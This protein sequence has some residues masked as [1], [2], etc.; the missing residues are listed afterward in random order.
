MNENLLNNEFSQKLM[1]KIYEFAT[2]RTFEEG[3]VIVQDNSYSR[4]I[5]FIT[6]GS[7]KVMRTDD[8][9]NEILLYYISGGD[10]C[11]MSFMN[12]IHQQKS[13]L[14]AIAETE[15]EVLLLPMEKV[16]VLIQEF[17]SFLS[18]IFKMYHKR[19]D[20]LLEM[21]NDISFKK[22]DERL[23]N[24]LLKKAQHN[25]SKIIN[26]T[27]EQLANELGTARVVVSRLLKQMENDGTLMLSR[28]KI[29]L[30]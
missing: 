5:P 29:S 27:H 1:D 30:M 18:Y 6:K 14:K 16:T 25:H 9:G 23:Y 28:N 3:D 12:G 7:I 17:P 15:C 22:V 21:I 2:I 8:E 10:S 26:T 11:I 13:K 19:F 4:S 20:E 24:L